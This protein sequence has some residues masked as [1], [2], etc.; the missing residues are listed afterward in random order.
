MSLCRSFM[1]DSFD[2]AFERICRRCFF[3]QHLRLRSIPPTPSIITRMLPGKLPLH[4]NTTQIADIRG[5]EIAPTMSISC[6]KYYICHVPGPT[7]RG[8]APLYVPPLSYKRGGMQRHTG[9]DP[10][11]LRSTQANLDSQLSSSHS[12]TTH[13][14]VGYYAP[15]ARTTLNLC[16]LGCSSPNLVTGKT[17]KALLILGFMAGVFRHPAGDFLSDN[18]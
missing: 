17:L 9:G 13:S 4:A 7:C 16:V 2:T 18:D 5:K 6:S 3:L 11:S 12:N 15:A 14:G 8:S 10:G 1:S